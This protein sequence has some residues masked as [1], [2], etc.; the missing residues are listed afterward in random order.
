MPEMDV[1]TRI[2][3]SEDEDDNADFL[4]RWTGPAQLDVV[5]KCL[6]DGRYRPLKDGVY[7]GITIRFVRLQPSASCT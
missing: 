5:G 7:N 1:V 2:Y 3:L 6:M 4:L